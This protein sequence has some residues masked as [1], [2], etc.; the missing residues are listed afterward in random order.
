[1]LSFK[2]V[3]K[4]FLVFCGFGMR[5]AGFRF[6]KCKESFLLREDKGIINFL[7]LEQENSVS[8]T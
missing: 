5:S 4:F 2:K 1:M 6:R 8:E 3:W 7:I